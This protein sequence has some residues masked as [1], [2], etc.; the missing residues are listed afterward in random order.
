MHTIS[1]TKVNH[2]FDQQI[3]SSAQKTKGSNLFGKIKSLFSRNKINH[4]AST[5]AAA[6]KIENQKSGGEKAAIH[7]S[8]KNS[9]SNIRSPIATISS[10][11][12]APADAPPPP[13]SVTLHKAPT[14]DIGPPKPGYVPAPPT[15][16]ILIQ[17][18]KNEHLRNINN[19][20]PFSKL[21]IKIAPNAINDKN[22]DLFGKMDAMKREMTILTKMIASTAV[23]DKS[24]R[25]SEG[26]GSLIELKKELLTTFRQAAE[27]SLGDDFDHDA[28]TNAVSDLQTT[29]ENISP[30][31]ASKK[32]S[33]MKR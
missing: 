21:G 12:P 24:Q 11:P 13:P 28:I 4:D 31:A 15:K 9:T 1:S 19:A 32:H 3:D 8:L 17:S 29:L 26:R 20:I 6:K 22:R 2:N 16:E 25:P 23:L 18:Q 30:E 33:Y 10:A 5:S 7:V 27:Y 14:D